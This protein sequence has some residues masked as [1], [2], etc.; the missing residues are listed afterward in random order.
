M[1]SGS[2]FRIRATRD[3]K[4]C[5]FK[6]LVIVKVQFKIN[7]N[8]TRIGKDPQSDILVKGFGVGK[9]AAIINKFPDGWHI[10]YVE[11]LSRPRVNNKT[12][13]KSIELENLDIVVIGST[14]LQ[15]FIL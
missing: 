10:N 9:T 8:L 14:K 6:I 11:G 5:L 15:F 1:R 3:N 12:L 2:T 4:S 7:N 13:K